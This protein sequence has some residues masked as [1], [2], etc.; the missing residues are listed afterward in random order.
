MKSIVLACAIL[1]MTIANAQNVGIG[2]SIPHASS[3]LELNSTTKGLL[4]PRMS[5]TERNAIAAPATGLLVFDTSFHSFWYYNVDGWKEIAGNT[6]DASNTLLYGQQGGTILSANLTSN[7]ILSGSSGFLYD[8]GGP[9]GNYTNNENAQATILPS[10]NQV[11]TD[12]AVTSLAI[13]NNFDS[14]I[15][16]DDQGHRYELMGTTT[17]TFRLYGAT[18]ILFKSNSTTT[19]AGFAIRW[20]RILSSNNSYYNPHQLA[21]WYFN[22]SEMYMRGGVNLNNYWSP[23]SSG[24]NSFVFGSNS[25]ASGANAIA[26]GISN[27]ADANDGIAL[28]SFNNIS[29]NNTVAIGTANTSWQQYAVAMGYRNTSRGYAAVAMGYNNQSLATFAVSLGGS[30]I[31]SGV[32]SFAAGEFNVVTGSNA[33]A[34]GWANK[35]K[36]FGGFVV[37]Y[38]NDSADA[39]PISDAP[40]NRIFQIGNGGA[41]FAR[42]NAMTVL[43][44]GNVG[45]GTVNPGHALVVSKDIRLDDND[46]NSGT[47][48]NTLR[49]GNGSTGEA[50][51]SR[52]TAGVNQWGLDF[53]TNN[54]SRMQISNS[55]AVNIN[56]NLTVQNGKG[57]IRSIDG[58]Q[59]K[60]LNRDV[61]VNVT[62]AAGASTSI[63]FTFPET[64][65]GVPDVY[66]GQSGG[67]G[68]WAEVIMSLGNPTGTGG[69]LYINNPRNVSMSPNFTVRIIAIG[70]Q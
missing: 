22:P 47:I 16:Y 12:I 31:A 34:V 1:S 9:L 33:G 28:G 37:G 68:G 44:N 11:A 56:N 40:L 45:I 4:A 67:A 27:R 54:T 10:F 20:D 23:D 53:Y 30:N 41:D 36:S 62:L 66:L 32:G 7:M 65:S 5:T 48:A 63:N 21:G 2:T 43:H 61:L 50:I 35:S 8:S 15:I 26:M 29:F 13:E 38:Y 42:S 60:K 51:G 17:G 14:L 70:P 18:K 57:I 19:Q 69:T 46:D 49:F 52:R 6:Y 59:L 3:L 55:G 24:N 64:F 58:T 39:D 25:K